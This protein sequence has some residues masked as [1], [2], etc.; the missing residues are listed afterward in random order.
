MSKMS[1]SVVADYIA[2]SVN[3]IE[4][5]R[6]IQQLLQIRLSTIRH[7]KRVELTV[8]SKVKFS[9][10]RVTYTGELIKIMQKNAHVRQ[11]NTA[12]VWRV[13]ITILEAV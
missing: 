4:D 5:V 7:M 1:T 6:Y 2:T 9:N 3:S 13:P 12:T 10:K 11:E 8:G